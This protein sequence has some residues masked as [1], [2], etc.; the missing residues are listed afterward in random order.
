MGPAVVPKYDHPDEAKSDDEGHDPIVRPVCPVER[1]TSTILT[2]QCAV[3][4]PTLNLKDLQR[5]QFGIRVAFSTVKRK[6][7]C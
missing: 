6:T 2:V 7:T 3:L 4:A 1:L 5:P